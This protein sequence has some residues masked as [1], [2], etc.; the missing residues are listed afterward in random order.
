MPPDFSFEQAHGG[1]VCGVD[2]AGRGPCAGPLVVAAVIFKDGDW[3]E[4][5]ND[6]KKL[7]ETRRFALEPLIKERALAWS[8]VSLSPADIDQLNILKATLL[9]M[10]RAVEALSP[11][12]EHA[13]IDG[14][15]CPE[16]TIS[17]EA[18]IKGDSRSLSISAAS[19]LAKTER[20]RQMIAY[21]AIY[22][23]Y[24]FADHKGYQA[25]SHLEALKRHGPCPIHRRSW[26]TIKA[27]LGEI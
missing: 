14:N 24:G 23:E 13:L 27:I 20:D 4:G 21:G 3:P 7:T 1:R 25:A 17:S 18:L 5:L 22:P 6:S 2:E 16:L 26:T 12:A 10:K 11:S 8:V 19:I 15:K 9:G